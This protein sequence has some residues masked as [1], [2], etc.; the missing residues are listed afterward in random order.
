[1]GW[2]AK[3]LKAQNSKLKTQNYS[4]KFKTMKI[5]QK[6]SIIV[7]CSL[8]ILGFLV[9]AKNIIGV[10]SEFKETRSLNADAMDFPKVE[11]SVLPTQLIQPGQGV[12]L[13]PNQMGFVVEG[14]GDKMNYNWCI[15]NLPMAGKVA[16]SDDKIKG[17]EGSYYLENRYGR[18]SGGEGVCN[19]YNLVND[20]D[21]QKIEDKGKAYDPKMEAWDNFYLTRLPNKDSDGD[22]LDDDWEIKMLAGRRIPQTDQYFVGAD[23][24]EALL[25]M[26]NPDD[27]F[28]NDG[29]EFLYTDA[30][31]KV[32]TAKNKSGNCVSEETLYSSIK[33][34]W[35]MGVPYAKGEI[36]GDGKWTNFE[37]Y[38]FGTDPLESDSDA[39]GVSDEADAAGLSQGQL[40]LRVNKNEGDVYDVTLYAFGVTQRWL[41]DRDNEA[42]QLEKYFRADFPNRRT[43]LKGLKITQDG[44]N[45]FQVQSGLSLQIQMGYSPYPAFLGEEGV[46]V[47]AEAIALSDKNE[48]YIF[49]WFRNGKQTDDEKKQSG[50]HKNTYKFKPADVNLCEEVIGVEVINERTKKM[51]Y[52]EIEIPIG[53]DFSFTKE[54]LGNVP[55][56]HN[57]ENIAAFNSKEITS[58]DS[59]YINNKGL[60]FGND[61]YLAE[62]NKN[63]LGFRKGDLIKFG[64]EGFRANYNP[65]CY[66]D[67]SFEDFENSLNYNW[68]VNGINLFGRSGK[69]KA[70]SKIK[71]VLTGEARIEAKSYQSSDFKLQEGQE[72]FSLEIKDDEGKAIA[73]KTEPIKVTLPYIEFSAQGAEKKSA[74]QCTQDGECANAAD[75]VISE[76]KKVKVTAYLYNFR[77]S[78]E[79]FIYTWMRN[80]Q[81]VA[82]EETTANQATYEFKAGYDEN[83]EKNNVSR[84]EIFLK[85][86]N[87]VDQQVLETEEAAGDAVIE[88]AERAAKEQGLAGGA[89]GRLVPSYYKNLFNIVFI[90]TV[91][92]LLAI[93]G[94]EFA[95]AKKKE[96]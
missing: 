67:L 50:V 32:C 49:N 5:F 79:R 94:I 1:L 70:F 74:P 47:K 53:L 54:L 51:E 10:E 95:K 65:S 61:P 16:G 96:E 6:F 56:N 38:V 52:Q 76:G 72:V 14:G 37:E 88:I 34:P 41:M 80:G 78:K 28:D 58:S 31:G 26:V 25:K 85:V 17:E 18:L 46:E 66:N 35:M 92:L 63:N 43:G 29:W 71:Y 20:Q 27:D 83:G 44:A 73:R 69:G 48:N 24:K 36:T 8:I 3:T 13:L 22:G 68:S 12:Q 81:E 55:F 40:N 89:L 7:G 82:K 62:V 39:D 15:D 77:P 64:I 11:Y 86:T 33:A 59:D 75:Y 2:C 21:Y 9:F 23:E 60:A 87:E 84:E 4:A 93:F 30:K 19:L 45:R 90:P 91:I 42:R 57:N